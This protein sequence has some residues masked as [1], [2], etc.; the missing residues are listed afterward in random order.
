MRGVAVDVVNAPANRRNDT[1]LTKEQQE[2]VARSL[3]LVEACT[4]KIAKSRG[5]YDLVY[6]QGCLG[7][8][9]A[10]Q[11]W[12][13]ELSPNGEAGWGPFAVVNIKRTIFRLWDGKHR[14]DN[15]HVEPCGS[16]LP[17]FDITSKTYELLEP[18][19]VKEEVDE[20]LS[21]LTPEER[22]LLLLIYGRGYNVKEAA[23]LVSTISDIDSAWWILKK[24]K[25][26]FKRPLVGKRRFGKGRVENL[27][28]HKNMDE[29]RKKAG[30]TSK[31]KSVERMLCGSLKARKWYAVD[32]ENRTITGPFNTREEAGGVSPV[33]EDVIKILRKQDKWTAGELA[34][35]MNTTVHIVSNHL[36]R[37]LK[38]NIIEKCGIG[39]IGP[40]GG[41]PPTYWKLCDTAHKTVNCVQ[42]K[43]CSSLVVDCYQ[44]I[45]PGV[46]Q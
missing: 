5:V 16:P 27:V 28:P 35:K 39:Q 11:I 41:R 8:V 38:L 33:L 25:E 2:R 20:R 10:A 44:R 19:A 18:L 23:K 36:Q 17:E 45:V 29:A 21:R 32:H 43:E 15:F 1:P 30:L 9:K 42:G 3:H 22:S 14:T 34:Q 26:K 4:N 6:S 13:V 46:T 7:L 40:K 24:A 12:K 31:K 37:L